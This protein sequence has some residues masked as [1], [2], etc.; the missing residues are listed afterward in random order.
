MDEAA[1]KPLNV[2][3]WK[4]AIFMYLLGW[5][6]SGGFHFGNGKILDQSTSYNCASDKKKKKKS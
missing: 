5:Y 2:L 4:W 6:L 1:Q 3:T